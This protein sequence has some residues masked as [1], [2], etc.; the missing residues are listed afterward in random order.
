MN[1]ILS[2]DAAGQLAYTDPDGKRHENILVVRAYPISAPDEGVSLIGEDGHELVWIADLR[3]LSAN[4]LNLVSGELARRE[5]MPKISRIAAVSSYATP[6]TWTVATD[7]GE[8]ELILKA[9]DHI[10]RLGLTTL[11]ITDSQG[12]SFLIDDV[13]RLDRH[14]RKLLDRFL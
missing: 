13:D 5:F 7:R 2:L 10:R 12:I 3:D 14:S 8:T 6:S 4:N 1:L 11:L 9:E